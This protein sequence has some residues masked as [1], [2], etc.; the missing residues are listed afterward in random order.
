MLPPISSAFDPHPVYF[1]CTSGSLICSIALHVDGAA[2]TSNIDAHSW[3]HICTSFHN[4]S[5]DLCNALPKVFVWNNTAFMA[6]CLIAL[7]K[8]PGVWPIGVG[9]VVR[10]KEYDSFS[11]ISSGFSKKCA[12]IKMCLLLKFVL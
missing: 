5:A 6:C 12:Y 2:G 9:E 1:D 8:C 4:A 3:Y 7:D 10:Q 11:K